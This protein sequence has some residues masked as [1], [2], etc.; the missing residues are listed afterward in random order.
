MSKPPL[1]REL[2]LGA[3]HAA[4]SAEGRCVLLDVTG[5]HCPP[6][7]QMDRTTWLAP[8]VAAWVS[9]N[10][11]AVQLDQND[12]SVE[13]F[14]VMA[15][16][17]LFLFRDGKE[18]DRTSGARP[19][20]P[21]LEWLDGA[22][23]GKTELDRLRAADPR[24]LRSRMQLANELLLRSRLDE[25]ATEYLWL[26]EHS[27]EV[28]PN[29]FGVRL[30]FLVGELEV[31]LARHPPAAQA[32]ARLRDA[33]EARLPEDAALEDWLALNEL[34][35]DRERILTWFDRV[36]DSP[37]PR[38]QRNR[39]LIDLLQREGRWADLGRLIREPLA[40]LESEHLVLEQALKSPLAELN[41]AAADYMTAFLRQRMQ[42]QAG[43]LC[44][45]LR[46]AGRLEDAQATAAQA[47]KLDPSPQMEAALRAS[48]L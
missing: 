19:P 22:M 47:R 18:L 39:R 38:L 34:L 42:E 35:D 45:A 5:E 24:D 43:N 30:S 36:R 15:V 31:L 40:A 9:E 11:V 7:Q 20:Q 48:D 29:F 17:T 6:C 44:R 4:A 23:Q 41:P 33:A 26:W 1:F 27:L 32:F 25:A 16:P 14:D 2:S 12:A 37:P 28:D 3:A 10:A 46:T 21:L 13:P 8:E